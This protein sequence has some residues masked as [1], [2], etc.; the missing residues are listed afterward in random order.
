MYL[1]L[2]GFNSGAGS[3]KAHWLREHLAPVPVLA[4]SYAA[5]RA[6]EAAEWLESYV[7]QA[8][9]QRE[10]GQRL[11]LVGSSLGGFWARYLAPRVGAG[12]VLV[13][14]CLW[15]DEELL[16]AVGRNHN[17]ATGEDYLF[18]EQD[19]RDF[20][21]LRPAVCEPRVAT[22]LLVDEGDEVLDYRRA[23]Q[24][25]RGCG[26][27]LQFAG[28]SHRFEHLSESLAAIRSLHDGAAP[29]FAASS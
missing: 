8:R 26:V 24:F 20:A 11:V 14:P 7:A 27:T 6:S 1:Y 10:A 21:R 28:G 22:L 16:P 9:A 13:N 15:P 25:Y 3:A 18:T 29:A 19:V 4:P 2:H 23:T 17:P 12:L 5:H